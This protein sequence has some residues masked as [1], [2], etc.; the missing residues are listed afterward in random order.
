[1][2]DLSKALKKKSFDDDRQKN[3]V[4]LTSFGRMIQRFDGDIETLT[5]ALSRGH[6]NVF[7]DVHADSKTTPEFFRVKS[8]KDISSILSQKHCRATVFHRLKAAWTW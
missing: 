2:D 3:G 1:M 5:E 8:K 4:R 6:Q 7:E